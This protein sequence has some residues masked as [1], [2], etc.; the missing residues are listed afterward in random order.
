MAVNEVL[1]DRVKAHWEAAPCGTPDVVDLEERNRWAELERIRYEREPFIRE[2]AA[3]NAARDRD[4]LEVGCG[5]GTDLLQFARA[6]ARCTAVDLTEAGIS[7]A[8]R[9]LESEGCTASLQVADAEHL[10]FTDASFDVIYSWGVIHHS[11]D[12]EACARE[13]LRVLRPGGRFCVM[14]Y[15]RRSLL[16]LQAWLVF[17]AA[18]GKPRRSIADV[19]ASHVESPGTKAYTR[20]EALQLF[21]GARTRH[22]DTVVTPYDLRIGR[23]RFLPSW[24]AELVPHQLGWFHVVTGTR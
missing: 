12:T 4:V 24:T 21:A 10:P 16:A 11:P 20:S 2:F 6:G 17:A 15:N 7:L 23:R 9:R 22:V 19:L 3:F 14:I 5:A 18:R 13:I 1:K 8:R